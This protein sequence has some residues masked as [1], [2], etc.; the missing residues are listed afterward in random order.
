MRPCVLEGGFPSS[1]FKKAFAGFNEG[2]KRLLEKGQWLMGVLAPDPSPKQPKE[3]KNIQTR[4][5]LGGL[6]Q[7]PA[8]GSPE[9]M[10]IPHAIFH[11][12]ILDGAWWGEEEYV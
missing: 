1:Y 2:L 9:N 3:T 8:Q 12:L 7:P 10:K 6:V 11:L 4:G 5:G